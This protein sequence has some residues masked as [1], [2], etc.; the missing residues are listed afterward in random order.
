MANT[1]EPENEQACWPWK[2][3][4]VDRY[5]YARFN[6]RIPGLAG[7]HKHFTAHIAAFVCNE[8]SPANSD[9]FY[10]AYLEFRCSGLELDHL[11]EVSGCINID[12]LDPTTRSVNQQ[13]IHDRRAQRRKQLC[14]H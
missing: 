14:L 10:L 8:A 2:G 3:K 4:E 9:E 1:H 5:G 6:L 12:H 11:C 13:R 7:K